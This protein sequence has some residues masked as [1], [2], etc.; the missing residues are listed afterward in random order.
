MVERLL[1]S[2]KVMGVRDSHIA[3]IQVSDVDPARATRIANAFAD[4]YIEK[5]PRFQARRRPLGRDLARRADVDLRKKLEDSEMDLYKFRKE[6]NLLDVGLD[7]KMGMTR[8]NLQSLNA[9]SQTS[10][11]SASS[12]SPSEA[13]PRGQEQ[14]QRAR[15]SARDRDNPVVQKLR[16]SYLDLLKIKADLESAMARSIP[17]RDHRSP[18]GRGPARLCQRVG[19]CPT[20]LRQ[21]L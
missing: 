8:Q 10:R 20:R 18:D 13:Y 12:W 5:K 17:D 3:N 6:R 7:D 16:E 1:R 19:R 15:K 9:R 2:V 4:T 21:A 14:H 11:P